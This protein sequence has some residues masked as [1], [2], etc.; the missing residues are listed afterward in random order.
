MKVHATV[1]KTE[2]NTRPLALNS[3]ILN[4]FLIICGVTQ[5]SIIWTI[6]KNVKNNHG[7]VLLAT[8]LSNTPPSVF[9]RFLNCTNGIKSRSASH[10]IKTYSA[11]F[12]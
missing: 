6:L 5:F 2:I 4:N 12:T 11:S 7:G 10:I 3:P 1:L 9:S 8:L